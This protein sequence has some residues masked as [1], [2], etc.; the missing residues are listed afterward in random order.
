MRVRI[1]IGA[2]SIVAAI[3][4]WTILASRLFVWMGGLSAYF[5]SPWVTW[6]RY[7]RQPR[8]DGSTL[9][10]L[11]ASGIV[12]AIPILLTVAALLYGAVKISSRRSRRPSLYGETAWA[13]PEEMV[14]GGMSLSDRF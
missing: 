12:A 3:G 14:E 4:V 8:I 2:I 6:W 9:V 5:P 11:I 1:T 7:A 13:S 10:Y